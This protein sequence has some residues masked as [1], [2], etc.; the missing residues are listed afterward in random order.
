MTSTCS[1]LLAF[2]M[3]LCLLG[4]ACGGRE[5]SSPHSMSA[6]VS[7]PSAGPG[8]TAGSS[9]VSA[10][11]SSSQQASPSEPPSLS[12]EEAEAIAPWDYQAMLGKGMDVD[13]SKTTQGR[14]YYNAQAAADLKAA[15]VSHVRIRVKDPAGEELFRSLDAQVADC[16]EAGLIPIIA[17]QADDFK[18]D[19]SEE[20]IQAVVGWWGTVARRY[21]G[22]SPLLSFD[23]LIEATDSRRSLTKFMS[24]WW[25]RSASPTPP[26]SL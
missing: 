4:T 26:G 14:K 8:S 24:A 7:D 1:R 12:P 5:A 16:L 25:R 3:A 11:S 22:V 18:N 17:Y 21:A 23:L 9:S 10:P 6:S 20:N 15:G 13:W 19:P 2:S